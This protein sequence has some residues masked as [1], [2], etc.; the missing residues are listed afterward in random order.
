LGTPYTGRVTDYYD[1]DLKE[2]RF[3]GEM[4]NGLPNGLWKYYYANGKIEMQ[5]AYTEGNPDSVW[6]KYYKDGTKRAVENYR[7]KGDSLHCDTLNIWYGN[8]RLMME[9][10]N[11]IS[12][13]YFTNGR[14]RS[15]AY[16]NPVTR[17]EVF[18]DRG[19]LISKAF[20]NLKEIYGTNQEVKKRIYYLHSHEEREKMA[21]EKYAWTNEEKLAIEKADSIEF[22]YSIPS[23]PLRKIFV[24]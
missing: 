16:G 4:K 5:G 24:K 11:E 23:D 8:G 22:D 21:N 1:N 18:N 2:L 15:I 9:S 6:I 19:L 17:E 3:M 14:V 13:W 12:T 20:G 10:V 7:S